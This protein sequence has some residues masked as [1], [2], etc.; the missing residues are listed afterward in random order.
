MSHHNLDF[1]NKTEWYKGELA[2]AKQQR[3]IK[4]ARRA[5]M[6]A[7][8]IV[9]VRPLVQATAEVVAGALAWV[10]SLFA[11]WSCRLRTRYR[12]APAAE[13]LESQPNPCS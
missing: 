9:R 3:M 8:P 6:K 11:S 7:Q 5:G 10:S 13:T 2:Y 1:Q 12:A 4:E